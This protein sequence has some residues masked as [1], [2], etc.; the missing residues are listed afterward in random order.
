[1]NTLTVKAIPK[2]IEDITDFANK[3]LEQHE[4]PKMIIAKIDIVIDEIV[5]NVCSYAYQDDKGE[6]TFEIGISG[7]SVQLIFKD[8][9]QPFDPLENPDPNVR[10]P[11]SRKKVGGLGIYMTKKMMDSVEYRFDNGENILT[12]TKSF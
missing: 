11:P 7:C 10:I 8:S 9:G 6:L 3:V 12:I 1:M 4:C 2:S 5:S